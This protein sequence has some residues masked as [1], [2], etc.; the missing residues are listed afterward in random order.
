[1]RVTVATAAIAL[2]AATL[3]PAGAAS[4]DVLADVKER[5]VLRVGVKA[6]YRPYGFLNAE[7]EIVGIEPDLAQDVADDLGVEL[8]M[9]PV[10]SSNRM[11]FLEQG[12]IDLMIAT[13]TDTEERRKVVRIV[14]PNYYSS[15]TNV[16]ARKQVGLKEWSDLEGAP[17]CGIQGAF[18][19]RKTEEE[20]GA[21]IVAFTGTAEALTA[22]EQNRCVAFVYDDAFIVSRLGEAAYADFEM[23]L[24]TIDDA[25]W[26]LAVALGEDAFADYM[27]EAIK[28]WHGSGRILALEDEYGVPHT[29]FSV[30]MHETYRTGG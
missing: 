29:P 9:I 21:E 25:P 28:G 15:G 27:S 7:G 18:Y 19:N 16:L 11:Q 14:D 20:F 26:G 6:D 2:A 5:G 12:R 1:M 23:P 10:V 3:G 30:K 24:D 22:L 13:M 8:E 17:V 4:A